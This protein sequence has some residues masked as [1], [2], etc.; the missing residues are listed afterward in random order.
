MGAMARSKTRKLLFHPDGQSL[1]FNLEKDPYEIAD[2]YDHPEYQDELEQFKK[3]I[4][5]WQG[6]SILGDT[7]LDKNALQI[8]KPNV[9]PID[10]S[11]REEIIAYYQKMMKQNI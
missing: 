4:I 9:P 6:K 5:K 11:H 1:Y 3:S 7:F 8:K 2:L 10:G